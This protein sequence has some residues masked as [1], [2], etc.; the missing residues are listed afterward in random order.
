MKNTKLLSLALSAAFAVCAV[1]PV[2]AIVS[3]AEEDSAVSLGDADGDGKVD[4]SDA[5]SILVNYSILSTGGELELAETLLKAAD[6]NEDGKIDSSDAS[7]ALQYYSYTSTG[8]LET[9]EEFLDKLLNTDISELFP[10]N[11]DLEWP[12]TE[13]FDI[14]TILNSPFKLPAWNGFPTWPSMPSDADSEEFH[15]WLASLPPVDSPEDEEALLE[16]WKTVSEQSYEN[17]TEEAE[18]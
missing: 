11:F 16:W 18:Q 10:F 13:P 7:Y 5:T 12:E 17:L 14:N 6:V 3:Q 9:I 1:S 15:N 8:G 2:T 4:A